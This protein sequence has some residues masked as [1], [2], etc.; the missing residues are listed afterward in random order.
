MKTIY[1]ITLLVLSSLTTWGQEVEE[2]LGPGPHDAQV[3]EKINAARVAYITE[4]LGLTPAEAEKFWPLYREYS[5]KQRSLKQQYNQARQQGKPAEELLDLEY[6][7]K[8][9]NLNL[10]KEY[11]GRLRQ[12][13]SPE[14]LMNLRGAEADFRKMVMQQVQQRQM[15]QQ[16]RELQKERIQQKQLQRNN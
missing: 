12:T 9:E 8:Q 14:K 10:E 3:R 16:R 7:L 13:I 1:M 6:T 4:R 2:P 5:D 15:N 11:A